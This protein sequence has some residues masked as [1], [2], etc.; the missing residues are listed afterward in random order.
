MNQD[1]PR[2]T[3][4][5]IQIVLSVFVLLYWIAFFVANGISLLGNPFGLS[6]SILGIVHL[7][8]SGIVL[9]AVFSWILISSIVVLIEKGHRRRFAVFSLALVGIPIIIFIGFIA[10]AFRNG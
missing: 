1:A 4:Y 9:I 3:L 6:E 7:V 5:W 10:F 2:N 8:P